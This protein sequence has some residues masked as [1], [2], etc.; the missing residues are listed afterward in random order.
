M[1]L[2]LVTTQ[3]DSLLE[4]RKEILLRGFLLMLMGFVDSVLDVVFVVG[5]KL[6]EAVEK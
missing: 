3:G 2:S 6:W 5:W 1:L 4:R